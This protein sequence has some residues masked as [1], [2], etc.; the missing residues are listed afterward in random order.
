MMD[1]V[2]LPLAAFGFSVKIDANQRDRLRDAVLAYRAAKERY[3][4]WLLEHDEDS[5]E[6]ANEVAS[7]RRALAE[8][9]ASIVLELAP[10]LAR[11]IAKG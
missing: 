1:F 10:R 2:E 9:K 8:T 11:E 5:I 6:L 7:L 3:E 4:I